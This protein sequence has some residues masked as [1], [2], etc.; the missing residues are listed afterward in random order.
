MKK[1]LALVVSVVILGAVGAACSSSSDEPELVGIRASLDPAVGDSR[2]L[3]AVNEIDGTRR[4]GPDEIVTVHAKSLDA[5][6]TVLEDEADFLWII[7]GSIGL[8]RADLPFDTAGTWEIDFDI[9]TGE[10]TQ[11]FLVLVQDEP[12]TVAIGE[13]APKVP[14]PTLADTALED[15]TTDSPPDEGFYEISLDE[16]LSNG[17]K[18]VLVFATPAFCTSAA[19]GPMMQN[20]KAARIGHPDV[21]W[22]HVEVYQGFNEDGFAPDTAHLAPAVVAYGLPSEPWVFVM[23]ED[24]VVVA[25]F[26][27]VLAPGELEAVL[28]A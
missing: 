27:G 28:D 26:E 8:Y 2:F 5:P 6:D 10:T 9:S 4:G 15:L 21:N 19:C 17:K 22:V 20:T 25:R 24:G 14:T 23:D 13:E 1:A 16:A 7:E 12:S 11:P 3:F 18:T